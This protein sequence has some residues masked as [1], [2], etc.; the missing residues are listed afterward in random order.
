[1][2]GRPVA[3]LWHRSCAATRGC[4]CWRGPGGGPLNGGCLSGWGARPRRGLSGRRPG[5]AGCSLPGGCRATSAA[6]ARGC[7]AT[8]GGRLVRTAGSGCRSPAAVACRSAR[9]DAPGAVARTT[10]VCRRHAGARFRCRRD[11]VPCAVGRAPFRLPC[12]A[13]HMPRRR[14][15]RVPVPPPR[16]APRV[17]RRLASPGVAWPAPAQVASHAAPSTQGASVPVVGPPRHWREPARAA[18]RRARS[19]PL[20]R[21]P[22][23]TAHSTRHS[24]LRRH[25]ERRG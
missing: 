3:G 13:P 5:A 20:P 11:T 18:S 2:T 10:P 22:P 21:R 16:R 25:E 7:R 24:T 6:V 15:G 1:M 8:S 23:E 4:A 17:P 14:A 12:R 19:T 9:R